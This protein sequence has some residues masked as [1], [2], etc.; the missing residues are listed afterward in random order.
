MP[1]MT[2]SLQRP[3]ARNTCAARPEHPSTP[4]PKLTSVAAKDLWLRFKRDGDEAA[5][6]QLVIGYAP[7]VKYAASKMG[8]GL[9]SHV[10]TADLVSY[11]LGGLIAAIDRFDPVR[12]VRFEAYALVRIR[13]AILDELRVIDWVPRSLRARGREIERADTKLARELARTPTDAELAAELGI[14]AGELDA[15]LVALSQASMVALDARLAR[16]DAAGE[17]ISLLDVLPDREETDPAS[18]VD[19]AALKD[20]LA[21]VVERLPERERVVIGLYYYEDLK[22]HEIGKV[23]GVTESRVS[24]LHTSAILR[25][26]GAAAEHGLDS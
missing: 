19:R 26:R 6:E 5:R 4:A 21:A 3:R 13:G 7:L 25:L 15:C 16:A 14:T 9:P 24:Q 23:L 1:T 22:L 20:R 10:E 8:S 18:I 2:T 12:Q 11:G 17:H